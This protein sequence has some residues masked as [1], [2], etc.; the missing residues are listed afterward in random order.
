MGV[1]IA[2][3]N[4]NSM[5]SLNGNEKFEASSLHY[6]VE[7]GKKQFDNFFLISPRGWTVRVVK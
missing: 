2:L 4:R 3:I 6:A 1:D 7:Y 5:W